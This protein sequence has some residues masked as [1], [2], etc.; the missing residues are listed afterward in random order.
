MTNANIY[1]RAVNFPLV[2]RSTVTP[3]MKAQM[4][5][6][7]VAAIEKFLWSPENVAKYIKVGLNASLSLAILFG[8]RQELKVS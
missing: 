5:E 8:N 1:N 3:Q 7:V 6:L 4:V 2:L